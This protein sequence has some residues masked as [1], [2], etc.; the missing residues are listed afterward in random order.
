MTGIEWLPRDR[1]R[2][3]VI[4]GAEHMFALSPQRLACG[5]VRNCVEQARADADLMEDFLTCSGRASH[6]YLHE[7]AKKKAN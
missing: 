2:A 7:Q 5:P 6:D 4:A 1:S 3:V